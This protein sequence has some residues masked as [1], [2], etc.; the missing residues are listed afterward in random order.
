MKRFLLPFG[1]REGYTG[2]GFEHW[3]PA[4]ESLHGFAVTKPFRNGAKWSFDGNMQVPTFSPSMNIRINTPDMGEH[5]QPDIESSVCHYFLKG[6]QIQYLPDC[7][8]ALKGKTV[9]LPELPER[10]RM[11]GLPGAGT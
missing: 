11:R 7:T 10:Y 2:E 8:H 5:Y 1:A 6:G 9:P 3:C 4:C